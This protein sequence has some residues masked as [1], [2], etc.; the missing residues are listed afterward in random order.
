MKNT[1]IIYKLNRAINKFK[2]DDF[3]LITNKASERAMAH[4]I[5]TYLE[6]EFENYNVDCEYNI[7]IEHN[8]DRKKIYLL[9]EEVK[10]YKPTHTVIENKEVSV[11]PDI[12]V[13]KRGTND[14]NL[15]VIEIKKDTSTINDEFDYFKLKKFTKTED[16]DRLFYSLGCALKIFTNTNMIETTYFENGEIVY[17]LG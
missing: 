12:I 10:K 15:L 9:E 2:K 14:R 8:S 3:Y 13:H 4:R 1:Q 17:I 5:A 16:G 6:S 7:N 11:F